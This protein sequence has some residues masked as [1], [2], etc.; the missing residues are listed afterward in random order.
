MKTLGSVAEGVSTAKGVKT[1]ID[2]LGV[3][4]PIASSVSE[5]DCQDARDAVRELMELPPSRELELPPT[6]GG[7]AQQLLRKLGL[8]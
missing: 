7:P 1:I 6:A 8:A 3:N 2:E 4:A 5:T